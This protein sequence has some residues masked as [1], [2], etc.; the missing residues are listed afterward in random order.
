MKKNLV[1]PLV[2]LFLVLASGL[3][4]INAYAEGGKVRGEDAVGPSLQLGDCPFIG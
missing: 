2:L 1:L 4:T 3:L